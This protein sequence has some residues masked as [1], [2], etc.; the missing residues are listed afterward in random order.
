M[1]DKNK[2]LYNKNLFKII[3]DSF[4]HMSVKLILFCS[5]K[6]RRSVDP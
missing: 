1:K 3:I 5:V 2:S 4:V 6:N